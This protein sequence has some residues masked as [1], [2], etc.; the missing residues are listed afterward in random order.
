[1]INNTNLLIFITLMLLSG[2]IFGSISHKDNSASMKECQRMHSYDTCR[3]I[4]R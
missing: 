3:N 2:A 4:L 1:M